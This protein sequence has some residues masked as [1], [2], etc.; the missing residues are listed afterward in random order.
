MP[1]VLDLADRGTSFDRAF[2]SNPLCCQSRATILTGLFSGHTGVWTNGYGGAAV[3]GWPAFREQGRTN[4]GSLFGGD[5]NNEGRTV[6]LSLQQAGYATGLFGKYLNHFETR[7]GDTPPTPVG[8]TS[9]HSFVG[10]NGA[11]YDYQTDDDGVV[12]THGNDPN[13]YSTDVFGRHARAFLRSPRIQDGTRP[14]FLFFSPFAPHSDMTPAPQ[15]ADVRA[16]GSFASP[17][18]NEL[19]VSDKPPTFA[20]GR[21]SGTCPTT[22]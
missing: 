6:A 8:W 16:P 1:H 5:G 7:S 3:G 22:R 14:F 13:D 10:S 12:H 20:I 21:C 18:Y 15:D 19:D 4:D 11:Y 17:A 2:V 9:W